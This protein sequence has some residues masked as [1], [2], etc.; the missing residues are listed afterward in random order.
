MRQ[1]QSIHLEPK[2]FDLLQFLLEHP[3][4]LVRKDELIDAVWAQAVVTDNALT[5]C[6]HQVRTALGDDADS[7]RYIETV[8]GSGYRF[9]ARVEAIA[10]EAS[11]A[12]AP[13]ASVAK[14][15]ATR[16][17]TL[18]AIGLLALAGLIW[19]T[20][21]AMR[22]PALIERLAVLPLSNLTGDDSQ[23]FV[24]EGIHDALITEL[25][26]SDGIDVIS[27]TSVMRYRD[28]DLPLPS[29]AD[30]L[31]VD[32]L[33]EGTVMRVGQDYSITAQLVAA[34]PERHLW[35][36]RYETSAQGIFAIASEIADTIAAEIG[37]DL[38][39]VADE[40]L[41][42]RGEFDPQ[43]YNL[44]IQGRYEFERKTPEAYRN[45][46]RLYQEAI[47]LDPEFAPAYLGLAHIIGS[48]AIFG[49]RPPAEAMP[50]VRA[51]A[52]RA[53]Q[54]DENLV[55]AQ[56]FLAGVHFYLDWDW[57]QAEQGARRVLEL[58]PNSANGY[59]FVADVFSA[60]GRHDL[61]VNAVELGREL[62]PMTA[63][64]Q[65][66]PV[67]ILYLK[68]DYEGAIARAQVVNELYPDLWQNHW[69]LCF[70]LSAIAAHPDAVDACESAV[71][72]SGN[73][74]N[75]LGGLGYAYAKAGMADEA[76]AVLAQI[77]S[78]RAERYVAP[79]YPAII[80]GALGNL[81]RAFDELDNAYADRNVNLVHIRNMGFF[82]PLRGDERFHA[83]QAR[84]VPSR[85][86]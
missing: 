33:I 34:S 56:I 11:G 1:G 31:N 51:L 64:G 54:I 27:R 53:L 3:G 22:P 6:V 58:N 10:T 19:L 36:E 47:D 40:L 43:A 13:G 80:H 61:A 83:L 70:S 8:P 7:P 86:R 15:A 18:A 85:W 14:S 17:L 78:M 65:L 76:N 32:A 4:R 20:I 73:T 42:A 69:L 23:L 79:I 49:L 50:E 75:A 26:R 84:I 35:A 77:E 63:S 12:G 74:P 2:S 60:T 59:R 39:P 16:S 48:S 62:D 29:I 71:T 37:L 45:A 68:R 44:Y 9:T 82:D 55:E 72:L 25:S 21:T 67:L 38:R 30:E 66:K 57:D 41:D 5:R 52:E 46:L 81:D 24:V 28:T